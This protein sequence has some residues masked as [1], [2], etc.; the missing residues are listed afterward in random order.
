MSNNTTIGRDV[1][2]VKA[3]VISAN[4]TNSVFV[5]Q[6]SPQTVEGAT[7]H[8]PVNNG[9]TFLAF[10]LERAKRTKPFHAPEALLIRK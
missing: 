2:R 8:L 7:Q 1:A 9:L 6:I 4:N 3:G 5:S 10:V